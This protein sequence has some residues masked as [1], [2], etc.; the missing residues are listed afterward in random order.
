MKKVY[1][2]QLKLY[3]Q[4]ALPHTVYPEKADIVVW[5]ISDRTPIEEVLDIV[6]SCLG[7]TV[8]V[9]IIAS[10]YYSERLKVLCDLLGDKAPHVFTDAQE[11]CQYINQSESLTQTISVLDF[12]RDSN[13]SLGAELSEESIGQLAATVQYSLKSYCMLTCVVALHTL[14]TKSKIKNSIAYKELLPY[15]E[16]IYS[17]VGVAAG[18]YQTSHSNYLSVLEAEKI[19]DRPTNEYLEKCA[20][21]VLLQP[22]QGDITE[23]LNRTKEV[24]NF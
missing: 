7:G 19:T 13:E 16:G 11:A 2:N 14:L 10:K 1:S 6:I 20:E 17:K 5:M 12:V 3:S 23:T 4:L 22:L 24:I 21:Y 8:E 9:Y 15:V 18:K